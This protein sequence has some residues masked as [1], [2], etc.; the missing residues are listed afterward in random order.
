MNRILMILDSDIHEKFSKLSNERY[1]YIT[2]K[3]Y[4]DLDRLIDYLYDIKR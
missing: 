3:Q 1:K 4:E 2:N